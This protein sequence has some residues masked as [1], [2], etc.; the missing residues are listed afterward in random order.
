MH[1]VAHRYVNGFSNQGRIGVALLLANALD[2]EVLSELLGRHPSFEI[3]EA[4]ADAELGLTRCTRL[5]PQVLIVDPKTHG[6][7]VARAVQLARSTIVG[8]V[9]V[10]DD[11]VHL[12][13]LAELLPVPSVSY[14]TRQAGLDPLVAGVLQVART[15]A[16]AFDP[17]A[18]QRLRRHEDGWELQRPSDRP[19]I[20]LLTA[21]ELEVMQLLASGYTVRCCAEKLQIAESTIDNHKSRLMKKLD[22]HK[23]VD[24]AH[25]AI[26]EGL[27]VVEHAKDEPAN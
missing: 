16:R 3:L 21:R 11:R 7:I 23:A 14:L 15:G 10:L 2:C 17:A 26:R 1:Q 8:H 9:I 13:R 25:E 18:R 12:G 19:S 24:L 20:A 4:T 5:N 6:E 27:I 22:I